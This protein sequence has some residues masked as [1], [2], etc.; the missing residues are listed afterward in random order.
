MTIFALSALELH[1][2]AESGESKACF[3][4]LHHFGG[5]LCREICIYQLEK[6]SM[7]TVHDITLWCMKVKGGGVKKKAGAGIS[8]LLLKAPR[9]PPALTSPFYQQYKTVHIS[10]RLIHCG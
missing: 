4:F 5:P 8:L 2:V 10:S 6:M 7:W 3:L 1:F 9:V